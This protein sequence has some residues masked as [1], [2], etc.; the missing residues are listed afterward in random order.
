MAALFAMPWG[1]WRP[2]RRSILRYSG[3]ASNGSTRSLS[4]ECPRIHSAP[5]RLS[6]SQFR[7]AAVADSNRMKTVST[8]E[9]CKEISQGYAKNAYPWL[10]S[11]HAS[12]VRLSKLGLGFAQDFK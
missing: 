2:E 8:A 4:T 10:I 7:D 6:L 1:R 12:G 9:R 5:N 11:Q 3:T